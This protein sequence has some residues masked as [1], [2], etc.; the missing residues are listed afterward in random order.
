[1]QHLESD[2]VADFTPEIWS[3][4]GVLYGVLYGST[5][6]EG[7]V[8]EE[9]TQRIFCIFSTSETPK[10][11]NVVQ[12]SSGVSDTRKDPKSTSS[13]IVT[14]YFWIPSY[15]I[16]PDFRSQVCDSITFQML[17]FRGM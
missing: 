2:A 9:E 3:S 11:Q 4:V 15:D 5:E 10:H 16:T 17:H 1:M 7:I 13:F 8:G 12:P 14:D 6:E